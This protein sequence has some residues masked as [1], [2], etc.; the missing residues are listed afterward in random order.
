MENL[1]D[2][3]NKILEFCDKTYNTQEV[4]DTLANSSLLER[5][6]AVLQ[7][8]GI[9]SFDDAKLLMDNLVGVDGKLRQ[10]VAYKILQLMPEYKQFFMKSEFYET[11]LKAIID[12]DSNVCRL[13]IDSVRFLK[14]DLDFSKFVCENL[15][16]VIDVAFVELS[17]L[18]FRT[19]KYT[20]NK[21]YFKIYWALETL[22]YFY[23]GMSLNKL[24]EILEKC[25]KVPEYTVREKCAVILKNDFDDEKMLELREMLKRDENY[26]VRN[27]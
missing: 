24:K 8:E 7:L 27:A 26:Y 1:N 12:I 20:S 17:K 9:R 18:S 21:Q 2:D 22:V 25:S 11:F 13:V 6:V 16:E 4:Y 3:F 5:Q 19:K 15:A 14:E 23:E 10:T